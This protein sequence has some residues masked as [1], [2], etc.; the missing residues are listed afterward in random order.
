MYYDIII[1]LS[2]SIATHLIGA[3]VAGARQVRRNS[4]WSAQTTNSILGDK[5]EIIASALGTNSQSIIIYTLNYIAFHNIHCLII[6]LG[7]NTNDMFCYVY[8]VLW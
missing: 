1:F 3:H 2:V 7:F 6:H 5:G 8:F 4:T